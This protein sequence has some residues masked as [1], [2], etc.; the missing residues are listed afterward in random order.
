M[1]DKTEEF[2][3]ENKQVYVKLSG[4]VWLDKQYNKQSLRNDLYRDNDYDSEDQLMEGVIVRL[5]DRRTGETVRHEN[6][7]EFYATTKEVT[8]GDQILRYYL[9][10]DV[11]IEDLS[12]Y[13]IEFEYDGLTYTNVTPHIDV[14]NGSKAAENANVRDE[15]NKNFSTIEGTSENTGVALDENGNVAHKLSYDKNREQH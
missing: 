12:N 7:E 6:G 1:V 4:Y 8:I 14:D 15:F 9:F 3:I 10:E 13:Y 2:V 11:L 5:K